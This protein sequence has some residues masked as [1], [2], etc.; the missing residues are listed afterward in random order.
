MKEPIG[1]MVNGAWL[2]TEMAS[3]G[4]VDDFRMMKT[5]VI[6]SITDKLTTV[7]GDSVLRKLVSAIDAVTDGT[8]KESTYQSGDGYAVGG[9]TVSKADWDYVRTARNTIFS[10]VG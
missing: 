3:V 5:P 8:A 4:D 9:K 7:S 1:M 2:G 10:D 6:S